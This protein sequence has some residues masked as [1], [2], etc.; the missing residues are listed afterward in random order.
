MCGHVFFS[1][2]KMAEQLNFRGNVCLGPKCP[3]AIVI[4]NIPERHNK[5]LI[6]TIEE[7][8]FQ[9]SVNLEQILFPQS[10]N[11]IADGAFAICLRLTVLDLSNLYNLTLGVGIFAGCVR[12]KKVM[13]NCNIPDFTFYRCSSLSDVQLGN[14]VYSIGIK[15]FGECYLLS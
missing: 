13:I 4:A 3:A 9:Q 7:K 5:I 8:A 11:L 6:T 10:I 15:G 1:N 2:S 14:S 12:L